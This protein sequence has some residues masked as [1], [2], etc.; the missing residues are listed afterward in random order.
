[1]MRSLEVRFGLPGTRLFV[2]QKGQCPN[3]PFELVGDLQIPVAPVADE[4][5]H[6]F[7][8]WEPVGSGRG[9]SGSGPAG[10]GFD[11]EERMDTPPRL[12]REAG[13]RGL[14]R[15]SG[16]SDQGSQKL[17]VGPVQPDAQPRSV[18]L[19]EGRENLPTRSRA[20]DEREKNLLSVHRETSLSV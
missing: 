1:M 8:V 6:G 15:T 5:D 17:G 16:R 19:G 12:K 18:Q 20:R 7:P 4:V 3:C 14:K 11:A 13:G 2:P 10:V 9:L